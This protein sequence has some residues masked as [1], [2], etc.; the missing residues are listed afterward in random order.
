VRRIVLLSLLA[1]ACSSPSVPKPVINSF[2]A[3]QTSIQQGG[4][5]FLH[6]DVTG[7]D[8]IQIDNG[9]G[10]VTGKTSV[11]V[12]P[13]TTTSY[14]LTATNAGGNVTSSVTLTVIPQPATLTAFTAS[15]T[16]SAS[17]QP[18][19]L[20]WTAAHAVAITLSA[21]PA[22]ATALP[23]PAATDTQITVNPTTSTNYTLTVIGASGTPQPAPMSL[24]VLVASV[25]TVVLSSSGTSVARG[26]STTLS[27]ISD[28]PATFTLVAKPHDGPAT[29]TALGTIN[30]TLV[31]PA[32]DTD[33]SIEALGPGGVSTSNVVTIAVTG[34]ISTQFTWLPAAPGATDAVAMQL[35]S[36]N[37]DVATLDLV[38]VKNITAGAIALELPFDAG[39]A[40]S[41]DGSARAT[42]DAALSG[43]VTAGLTVNTTALNP[44]T[45]PVAAIASIPS[46][47][48]SAGVLLVG[49]AQKPVCAACAGGVAAD[50]AWTA[51][52]VIA[53]VRLKLVPSG[54][55]GLI[56]SPGGL[57]AAHGFR[58]TVRSG[59][60]G[61]TLGT[62][63]VGTLAAN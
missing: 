49:A 18:V 19:V 37:G 34:A 53:S 25:P 22:P 1:A 56:F 5:T 58:S 41:R 39:V 10:D 57:D 44:G 33:Y 35:N 4:S 28:I 24:S 29:R 59:V 17:G 52:T 2:T 48:P 63:A 16:S 21:N 32:S 8:K 55:S 36:I 46:S 23:Q 62:I 60:T 42:L 26:T 6:F 31:R 11:S 50:N 54:G 20:Q 7:A 38:A 14:T 9:V 12:G 15:T 45:T 27:W 47:G 13:D 30:A 3:S 61:A 40:G 43:D 51:G